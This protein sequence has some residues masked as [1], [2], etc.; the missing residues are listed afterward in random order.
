MAMAVSRPKKAAMT[1]SRSLVRRWLLYR[2]VR[3]G[4]STSC[5]RRT[6]AV[7]LVFYVLDFEKFDVVRKD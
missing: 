4:A 6:V 7:K 1:M 5:S 2:S 3:D